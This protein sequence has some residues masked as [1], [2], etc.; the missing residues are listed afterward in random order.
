LPSSSR[1]EI[2]ASLPFHV[3]PKATNVLAGWTE[4]V[5]VECSNAYG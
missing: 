4:T 2:A 3:G 1:V 5:C